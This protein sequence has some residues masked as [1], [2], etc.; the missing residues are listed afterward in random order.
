M[1]EWQAQEFIEAAELRPDLQVH[2]AAGVRAPSGVS[3][4]RWAIAVFRIF[5]EILSNVARRLTS[6]GNAMKATVSCGR[7]SRVTALA[8]KRGS[9]SM[10]CTIIGWPVAK[11]RAGDAFAGGIAPALDLGAGQPVGESNR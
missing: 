8:R 5:Q 1:L 2:I 11:H 10:S 7:R 4:E 9:A 6:S 3:G